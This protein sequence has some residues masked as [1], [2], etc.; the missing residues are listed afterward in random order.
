[1]AF[2]N[3]AEGCVRETFGALVGMWQA[4]F[5]RDPAVRRTMRRI[6]RDEAR[7]AALSWG[8]AE[9]IEPQLSP[10][11]RR[12]LGAVQHDAVERLECDLRADPKAA[13][14]ETA[15]VPPAQA[16]VILLA[17]LRDTLLASERVV[18]VA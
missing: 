7:H 3:G 1:V 4:R 18:S 5:A 8:I 9:W 17:H 14:V 15:G 16:A 13:V 2:D 12:R 6:A 10:D 11:V